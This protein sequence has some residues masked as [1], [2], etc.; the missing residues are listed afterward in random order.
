MEKL[1]T[2]ICLKVLR[3]QVRGGKRGV[4]VRV[5]SGKLNCREVE[6]KPV[7]STSSKRQLL[8]AYSSAKVAR[9]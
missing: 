3:G 7:S 6:E 2:L 5:E 1:I 8:L 4:L 9:G